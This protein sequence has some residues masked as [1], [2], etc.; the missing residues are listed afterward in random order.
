MSADVTFFEDTPFFSPSIDHSSSLQEVLP[1]PYPCPL[2]DSDQNVSV[3]PSSSPTSP[4]V[5]SSPL[6]ADQPRTTLIGFPVPEASPRDSRSSST[7]PPLMDPSTSS[8]TPIQRG[9]WVCRKINCSKNKFK[10]NST[11]QFFFYFF[12]Q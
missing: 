4:E 3:V 2:D 12:L 6:I 1:I 7:S 10:P 5:V 9:S 11:T 8:C